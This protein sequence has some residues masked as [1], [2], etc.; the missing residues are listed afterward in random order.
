MCAR[1]GYSVRGLLG[2]RTVSSFFHDLSAE[3]Q[4]NSSEIKG[5]K[6]EIKKYYENLVKRLP[7]WQR[8][9]WLPSGIVLKSP[10]E[11]P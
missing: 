10:P 6:E 3:F 7:M 4:Q 2:N 1:F 9:P 11:K 8:S 5:L